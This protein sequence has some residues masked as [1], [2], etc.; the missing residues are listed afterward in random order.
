[1]MPLT[2]LRESWRCYR[3]VSVSKRRPFDRYRRDRAEFGQAE[4]EW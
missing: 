2:L 1:M 4:S 3:S